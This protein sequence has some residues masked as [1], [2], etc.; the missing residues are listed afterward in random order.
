MTTFEELKNYLK[1]QNLRFIVA[2]DAETVTHVRG[3]GEDL[4]V[5]M[6]AGGV[7][8]AFDPIARASNCVYIAR[9]KTQEDM[10]VVD[11]HDSYKVGGGKEAYTLKRIEVWG[12]EL[13]D[14]YFGFSNQTLWPLCH[15]S[16]VEPRFN[17]EWFRDF[18]KVNEKFAKS[19]KEEIKG[20]TFVWVNDYQLCL[21]PKLLEKPKDTTIGFFWHIPW[22][23]WEIFRILPQKKEILES[24]LCSDFIAFHR[25][26]Q[27]INFLNCV[28]RE[29]EARIDEEKRRIYYKG[30][31]T[32]VANLPMGIDTDVVKS[33]ASHSDHPR[34]NR[35]ARNILG[36]SKEDN[37][38]LGSLVKKYKVILGVDRLDYTKGLRLRLRALDRF[39][40]KNS[41]YIGK[42][43]YLGVIAPSRVQIASY[44]EVEKGVKE[45]A[46]MI[47]DK[48]GTKDYKPV[49]LV[50]DVLKREE[51]IRLYQNASVCL[52]TPLDD[53]MNLVSKEFV[54]ASSVNESGGMLILSEFAGSAIDLDQAIIVN[55]YDQ[56]QVAESIKIALEMKDRERSKR[57]RDMSGNLDDNNV[58][59]WAINF[60]KN[61]L[62]S[63]VEQ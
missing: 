62:L 26:Y 52:V 23:T 19:I 42:V 29:L 43:I 13:D 4:S 54:A 30:H 60:V 15:V 35:I 47:N 17:E 2:S 36:A 31:V 3:S 49:H 20:K 33:L 44:K 61:A 28:R 21:V 18:K 38:D 7:S 10:Q 6:S 8:T 58:Y 22:P 55:P 53:G 37:E 59:E 16:F 24:M 14:Y 1:S 48:Y 41:K 11:G 25:N 57:L 63:K 34:L 27:L 46:S 45:L 12:K 9:A 50:Y 51:V 40:E 39:F 56:K 5:H 32:T